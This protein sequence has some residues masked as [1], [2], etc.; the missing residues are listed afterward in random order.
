[1]YH[2]VFAEVLSPQKI[3]ESTNSKKRTVHK[4]LAFSGYS[5]LV[6]MAK[7]SSIFK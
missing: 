7:E 2:T 4:S 6:S 3:I 1:M 5:L